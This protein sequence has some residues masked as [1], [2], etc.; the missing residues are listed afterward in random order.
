MVPGL[1][2][3]GE[4]LLSAPVVLG[5]GV[6]VLFVTCIYPFLILFFKVFFSGPDQTLDLE[7][8][9]YVLQNRSTLKAIGNTLVVSVATSLVSVLLALPLAWL[10]TQ[11]DLPR[12]GIFRTLFCLPYAIPP[13]IGAIAWI[14]LANP[15]NGFLVNVFGQGVI[16]VYTYSGLIWVMASFLYTFVLLSL[17]STFDR[18]D[19]SLIEAARLSGA[20]PW[21]VFSQIV[22]PLSLPSLLSGALLVALAS[23]ASF[24]VPALIGSPARIFLMTT[25]IYTLQKMGSLNGIYQAGALSL[26]LLFLAIFVLVGNQFLHRRL[27]FQTV[28]GKASRASLI[29]LGKWKI[30]VLSLLVL[31]LLVLFFLPLGGVVL[32]ALARVPGVWGWDNITTANFF[33]FFFEMD[34]TGRA[35]WNF[36][37]L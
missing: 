24:G 11:T 25:K 10:L 1:Q 9:A 18:M 16:N 8:L 14:Y 5:L 15:T 33:L 29:E 19:S 34:E 6:L 20:S 28:G 30:P 22:L 37:K 17:L 13:Y 2:K 4:R 12:P 3:T 26:V 35:L 36:F 7:P 21:R 31:A 23:A 27:N 32:T